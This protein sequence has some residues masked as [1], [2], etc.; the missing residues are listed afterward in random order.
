MNIPKAIEINNDTL[1]WYEKH[2]L[3]DQRD[4]IKLGI[5]AL[6]RHIETQTFNFSGY[7]KPLPGETQD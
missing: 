5:E 6:K 7:G 1:Y 4:A 2:L 3:S